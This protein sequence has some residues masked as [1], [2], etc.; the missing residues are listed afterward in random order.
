MSSSVVEFFQRG[1]RPSAAVRAAVPALVAALDDETPDPL[2]IDLCGRS[3]HT[4][5]DLATAVFLQT[6]AI[7]ELAD[8]VPLLLPL[9]SHPRFSLRMRAAHAL[10]GIGPPARPALMER[11][12][13]ADAE[14]RH[15]ILTAFT[16][17]F[18]D[19]VMVAFNVQALADPDFRVREQAVSNLTY[20]P[21]A[22]AA[23]APLV[24]DPDS[25][26]RHSAHA[27]LTRIDE[28]LSRPTAE[29]L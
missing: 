27:A 22:R 26:V 7:P 13:S 9:L 3:D 23:V 19:P 16:L 29:A 28:R 18:D 10:S 12:P 15:A 21:A 24:N 2:D 25:G 5:G 14:A 6:H 17:A 1:T 11:Y 20:S 4:V 8:A